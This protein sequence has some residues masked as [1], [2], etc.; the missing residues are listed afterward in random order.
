MTLLYEDDRAWLTVEHATRYV[1]GDT[2][3]PLITL[4]AVDEFGVMWACEEP[5]GWDAPVIVTPMDNR[6]DG[7]GGY[8]GESY[9]EPRTL[10]FSGSAAAPTAAAAQAA[11]R[12]LLRAITDAVE[13]DPMLYSHVDE[14][15]A[16]SLWTVPSGTPRI[17]IFDGRW[18]DFAFVLVAEDPIKFGPEQ[19]YGPVRLLLPT[20]APG[21]ALPLTTPIRLTGS[22]AL[23]YD[24]VLVPNGGDEPAQVIYTVT[25]PIPQP[26][27]Q[28][29][30]GE[31]LGLTIN[32]AATDT[33]VADTDAG[34]VQ[35]NGVNRY[36]AWLAGSTFPTIPPGGADVRLRSGTGSTDQTPGLTITTADRYR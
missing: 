34:T 27:I 31:Y 8:A 33:M 25:G 15:P 4:N 36:D 35:V 6:Q 22:N 16:L 30:S 28:I 23:S 11:R 19:T 26:I 20:A 21:V 7:H 29:A 10:T 12:R 14:D 32:L 13:G 17:T 2:D 5:T 18:L 1:L 9:Y 3:A 24:H